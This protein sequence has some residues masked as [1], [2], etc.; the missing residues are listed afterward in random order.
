MAE[1]PSYMPSRA[2]RIG[3]GLTSLAGGILNYSD[4]RKKGAQQGRDYMMQANQNALGDTQ[5]RSQAYQDYYDRTYD[6]LKDRPNLFRNNQSENAR[7]GALGSYLGNYGSAN[8][9]NLAKFLPNKEQ[10]NQRQLE[11]LRNQSFMDATYLPMDMFNE[12]YGAEGQSNL[13]R[14]LGLPENGMMQSGASGG[15]QINTRM[16][17]EFDSGITNSSEILAA[18]NKQLEESS[19]ASSRTTGMDKLGLGTSLLGAILGMAKPT[20]LG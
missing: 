5:N 11:D 9:S 15:R 12:F 10:L 8:I 3:S 6:R 16:N 14:E 2:N 1:T 17:N 13:G 7:V 20:M 19:R 18:I 4:A